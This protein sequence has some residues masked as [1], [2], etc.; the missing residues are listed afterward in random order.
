[1]ILPY[2][3]HTMKKILSRT[4]LLFFLTLA[5]SG[6]AFSQAAEKKTIEYVLSLQDSETGAFKVTPEGKPSV[7]ACNGAMKI[8]RNMKADIPQLGKIQ[9]FVDSRF[10]PKLGTF[11]EIDTK[12]DATIAAIGI[13]T[14]KEAGLDMK[15]Y[16]PALTYLKEN[17]KGWEDIRVAGAAAEAWGVSDLP[18]KLD[19]WIVVAKLEEKTEAKSARL[20]GGLQAF[21]LRL[22]I[23]CEL[24]NEIILNDTKADG[25]WGQ[26]KETTSDLETMYRVMRALHLGKAKNPEAVYA[27]AA[28][29]VESCRNDD[30]G[31]GVK[32]KT[33]STMSGTYYASMITKWM[34]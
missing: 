31:Y 25:G 2:N 9:K 11:T 33:A 16:S 21:Y 18:V 17:A 32:P 8:L 26:P 19:A 13:I 3:R 34:K 30:G 24:Q 22:N 28:K 29:F 27:K 12:P 5:T 15:K 10:D 4:A 1:M 23:P 20:T 6:L 7:R 14:A